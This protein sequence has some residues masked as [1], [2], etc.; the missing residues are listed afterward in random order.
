[1]FDRQSFKDEHRKIMTSWTEQQLDEYADFME[2]KY[3]TIKHGENVVHLDYFG[4]L[5]DDNDIANIEDILSKSN[6][7]LSRF[8]KNG[9]PYASV[10]DFMLQV[11]LFLSDKTCQDVLLGLGTSALWDTIKASTFYIWRTVRSRTINKFSGQTSKPRK[12]NCG[13]KMSLDKN[14]KF[15]F[16]IDGELSDDV[17]LQSLD[18]ILDFLKTVKPNQTIK[19]AD[20]VVYDKE[21]DEWTIVDVNAEI[22]KRMLASQKQNSDAK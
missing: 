20:F 21:K 9:I 14:T 16:K 2:K 4:G 17:A 5:I 18:K 13:I 1:M 12:I 3:S 10:E 8:D 11:A 15:E 7:E 22:R 19:R 6:L